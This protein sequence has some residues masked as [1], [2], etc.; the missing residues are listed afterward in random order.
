[1]LLLVALVALSVGGIGYALLL[2]RI[3]RE[4]TAD[5]RLRDIRER[6][7]K[8]VQRTGDTGVRRAR[9][10]EV[11]KDIEDKRRKGAR[12][13]SLKNQLQQ[14]GLDWSVK[15]FWIVSAAAG[16]AMFLTTF[17]LGSDLALAAAFGAAGGLGA[18][19]WL[20]S[21][22]RKRR[23][24]NFV[25][26]FPNA[27]DVIVRGIKAGLPLN[28]C[29][30][31]VAQE[32]REP[33]KSE[34]RRIAEAQ[35]M[36]LSAAD[37]MAK[38]YERVAVPEA[39]FFAI[40]LGIQQKTGGNLSET[41]GNL[42]KVLRDR[43]KM[44][45]KIKALSQEAKASAAIIAALPIAVMCLIYITTPDYISLLWTDRMGHLMLAGSALWMGC[46][47]LVMRKMINFDF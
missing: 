20:L 28:D 6:R 38:L 35:V 33:V 14:S 30:R 24:A 8:A 5:R 4:E 16:I 44:K 13:A 19:R 36:G 26:E 23:L 47:V 11:L 27:I 2:P 42:S 22:L 9:V 10:Q 17:A 37:A 21:F 46:G 41:L 39:N 1:M 29:I 25:D 18:P 34:F 45:G 40:T 43:K 15:R 12:K 32:A 7:P 31:I 3:S